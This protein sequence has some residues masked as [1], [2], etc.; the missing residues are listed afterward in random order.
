[1]RVLVVG[2]SN[3]TLGQVTPWAGKSVVKFGVIPKASSVS[4][5][6][7]DSGFVRLYRVSVLEML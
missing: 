4:A 3:K 6:E 2:D 7:N 5:L 1:M